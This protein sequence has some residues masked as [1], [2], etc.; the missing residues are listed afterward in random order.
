MAE[1]S[2]VNDAG[3][4]DTVDDPDD[5]VLPPAAGVFDP[6]LPHA[7]ASRTAPTAMAT[8]A[9]RFRVTRIVFPPVLM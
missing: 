5:V 6:E 3:V 1:K 7:A 2:D 8:T 9:E 4:S